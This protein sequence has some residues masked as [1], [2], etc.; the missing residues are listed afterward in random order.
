M[1]ILYSRLWQ[2]TSYL[3]T[4]CRDG[5]R[6]GALDGVAPMKL[7]INVR[8]VFIRSVQWHSLILQHHCVL[9][10]GHSTSKSSRHQKIKNNNTILKV[11]TAYFIFTCALQRWLTSRSIGWNSAY[12]VGHKCSKYI[13]KISTVTFTHIAISLCP[14]YGTQHM[15]VIQIS[16]SE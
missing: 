3:P 16:E 15:K 11:V 10:T 4:L 12:E 2:H 14:L 9:Y 5:W 1:T 7:V 8:N 6:V 13:H